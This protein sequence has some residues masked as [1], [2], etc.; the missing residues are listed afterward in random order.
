MQRISQ[1]E[2]ENS[3]IRERTRNFQENYSFLN[4]QIADNQRKIEIERNYARS[5]FVSCVKIFLGIVE[6]VSPIVTTILQATGVIAPAVACL[7]Q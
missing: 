2:T 7:I 6:V 4:Q 3:Q 5:N 1:L